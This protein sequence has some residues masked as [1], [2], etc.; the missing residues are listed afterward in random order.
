MFI[1]LDHIKRHLNID[2]DY[3]AEDNYIMALVDAAE[4]VIE[5]HINQSLADLEDN[6]TIP[7][8]L[9]QAICLLVGNWYNN[10]ES[11]S[12]INMTEVPLAFQY[13]IN[14][15]KNYKL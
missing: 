8:G 3:I 7:M 6:G 12:T 11:V 1:S 2:E 5:R 14:T 10:R 9:Q 13:L 15:Y 4:D